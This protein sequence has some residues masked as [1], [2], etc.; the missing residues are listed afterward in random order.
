MCGLLTAMK[1]RRAGKVAGM[2]C[3]GDFGPKPVALVLEVLDVVSEGSHEQV[4]LGDARDGTFT[5]QA[6]LRCD[7][8]MNP[9][10]G[11]NHR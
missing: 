4:H 9:G 3:A 6:N 11:G 1:P 7:F 5:D 8:A 2:V 10:R